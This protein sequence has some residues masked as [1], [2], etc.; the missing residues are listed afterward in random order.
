MA[1]WRKLGRIFEP[2]GIHPKLRTHA[3][4]PLAVPL[5]DDR[6]RIYYSGRDEEN[7]SSVSY[8]EFDLGRLE[9]TYV[10]DRPVIE[11]G[12]PGSFYAH[13]ISIGN[14]YEVTG[15]RYMLFMGWQVPPD[16]HWRG[17]IGRLTVA[18]DGR[19][20]LDGD[21]PF[22]G[23][24]ATDP[25]SLSYPWV[26]REGTGYRMWYGST[27]EWDAGNGEML[28]V[29]NE[30]I[31]DDGHTW[32]LLGQSVPHVVGVAQAFS[33]PTVL[34]QGVGARMW[35]SYRGRPGQTYRI[36]HARSLD[37]NTWTLDLDSSGI[38]VSED[39]WD[40]GMIEYPFAFTHNGVDY[41]LYN[42]D[43]YGR[44]GFGLAVWED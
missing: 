11:H 3:A 1:G 32:H 35:F 29:I 25:I 12:P 27:R 15:R 33:R 8:I 16:S 34:R 17:D 43:G 5:G 18:D 23:A 40:A 20:A 2:T 4:N 19:L 26:E 7:R 30:A 36:G 22:V 14:C 38:D 39:G 37:D 13:G 42:G 9:T 44:T 24:S 28:H 10:H 31:S 6:V 21:G 41:L